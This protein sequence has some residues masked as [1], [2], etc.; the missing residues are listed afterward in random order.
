[1]NKNQINK[2]LKMELD[3][4]ND[5]Q[6]ILEKLYN[7]LKAHLIEKYGMTNKEATRLLDHYKMLL[8]LG[9]D[10]ETA[11]NRLWEYRMSLN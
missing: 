11:M 2:I 8:D 1:M 3:S 5:R 7:T 9:L 4:L 10:T 6:L